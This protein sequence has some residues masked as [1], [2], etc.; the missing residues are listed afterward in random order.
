MKM[1]RSRRTLAVLGAIVCCAGQAVAQVTPP[2]QPADGPGGT[3][4]RHA[5]VVQRGPYWA[6][7]H[8]LD[9]DYRYFL[10]EPADPT[11]AE[12]PVVL[13]LHGWLAYNPR[14]Y[15]GWM[16]HMVKMGHTVVW[17]QYDRFLRP[18]NVLAQNAGITWKDAL[19]RLDRS[20][21][22]HVRPQRDESGE[23]LAAMVGH[24]IGGSLAV[25]LAAASTHAPYGLPVPRA[26]V[27]VTPGG[28]TFLPWVDPGLLDPST[29]MVVVVGT[30]DKLV[31]KETAVS[32]WESTPQIPDENRDFL[33]AVSDS[34]GI[35]EQL[36]NHYFPNTSGYQDTAQIDA[37]DFGITYKLSVGALDCVFRGINC[38]Y[39]IGDGAPEQIDMGR[40]SDGQPVAPLQWIED[41]STLE[42]ICTP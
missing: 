40:W 22:T 4:Y 5:T 10:F 34:W 6:Q 3:G 19:A 29:V 9:G 36:G 25:I 38:S 39:A 33:L 7:G 30:E 23:I 28:K 41:P 8:F 16:E 11:P 21:E 26:V 37:R 24:S 15:R 17:V 31:C 13:F 2:A 42:T 18:F 35:P 32:I 12:A 1:R 14:A 20:F 27:S